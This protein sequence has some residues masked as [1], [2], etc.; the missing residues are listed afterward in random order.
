MRSW[1]RSGSGVPPSLDKRA[2]IL[3]FGVDGWHGRFDESFTE[4][5]VARLAD[6]LGLVWSDQWPGGTVY[7]GYDTRHDARETAGLIAG[8][9]AS[10]GLVV[11]V[12]DVACPTPCVAWSCAADEGALGA[13]VVTASERSCEHGGI[14]VRGADGGPVS[15]GLLDEIEQAV[16]LKPT[17]GRGAFEECDLVGPYLDHLSTLVDAESIASRRPRV[18]VDAM[19][20]AGTAHLAMLLRRLGCEVVELHAE[21]REDFGGIHPDPCDPWADA[22]EQAVVVQGADLGL[23][24]DGDADRAAVV[25]ERGELLA[26]RI[27]VPLVLGDVVMA[28]GELGRVV[29]T[30]SCSACIGRQA[31][32]LGCTVTAVPVGFNRVYRE[33]LEGDVVMGVEEYGGICFPRHLRERDGLLVCLLAVEMLARSGKT[34]SGMAR[35]LEES[36]GVMWYARRDVRLDPAASQAFR[37]I[38]PGLNPTQLN[39]GEIVDVSH[40]DGLRAQFSDGS[41]ILIRPSR[42]SAV[43]RVYA[44]A[45]TPER[46]DAL[47]TSACAYVKSG[48]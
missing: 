36:V 23:L 8:I 19:Y 2:D 37:N 15:R 5:N 10:Y 46:L 22:C 4:E 44:E 47:L 18:V 26:A 35:E 34:L 42:A 45:S 27:L 48:Y 38:L 33:T 29:T 20:G 6:A 12:S 17:E 16:S 3:R 40:A 1:R 9:L 21:P 28:H 39:E 13:V 7:V 31:S 30:L 25:N 32:L 14:L 11:K 24:L 43:V 41:W